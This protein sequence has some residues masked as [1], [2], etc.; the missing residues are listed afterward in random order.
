MHF[1]GYEDIHVLSKRY[2]SYFYNYYKTEWIGFLANYPINVE[3][4]HKYVWT[5]NERWWLDKKHN[6]YAFQELS[7]LII[8]IQPLFPQKEA[9]LLE[10]LTVPRQIWQDMYDPRVPHYYT[11]IADLITTYFEKQWGIFVLEIICIYHELSNHF[12]FLWQGY[13]F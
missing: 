4:I 2:L 5:W 10:I 11:L 8:S 12:F 3:E 9:I 13:K 1:D 7:L 6:G